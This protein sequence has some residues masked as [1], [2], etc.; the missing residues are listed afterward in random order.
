MMWCKS[1]QRIASTIEDEIQLVEGITESNAR[2]GAQFLQ[3]LERA[4]STRFSTRHAN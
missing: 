2:F 4:L 3:V 1:N